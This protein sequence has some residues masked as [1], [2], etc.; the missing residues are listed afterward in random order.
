M[1]HSNLNRAMDAET[2]S[3][4]G[5]MGRGKQ[6]FSKLSKAVAIF[7]VTAICMAGLLRF[8][9]ASG[10]TEGLAN[11][12]ALIETE[13][14]PG[15]V[16]G[17]TVVAQICIVVRDVEATAKVYSE[18]FGLPYSINESE[19]PEIA[20]LMHNGKPTPARCK[21]AFFQMENIAIELL[22]PDELPSDWRDDLDRNGEGL[23]HLG[24]SVK[25]THGVL[26]KM[27]DMGMRTTMIGSFG[28]G[29]F[30]YADSYDQLKFKVETLEDT[31]PRRNR[32]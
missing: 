12:E 9:W 24:F 4:N 1:E 25:D 23:H 16:L 7:A 28:N 27:E 19:P 2:I 31:V 32:R 17:T 14:A 18:F 22:Q 13:V 26:K 11:N 8:A 20:R 29:I 15:G 5:A 30:A 21:M 6:K 10:Y 3:K